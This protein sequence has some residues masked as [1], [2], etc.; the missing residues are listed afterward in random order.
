MSFQIDK[1]FV[2]VISAAFLAQFNEVCAD[3]AAI[4][5]REAVEFFERRVWPVL[6]EH[7]V[8]CHGPRKQ[9]SGLR[10]DSREA[11]LKGGDSGPAARSAKPKES[12]LVKAVRRT[13]DLK[14]PPDKPLKP[15]QVEA[16]SRWVMLGLPWP[17]STTSPIAGGDD[18]TSHWAFQPVVRPEPPGVKD[19]AWPITDV[20]RFVLSRLEA[21]QLQ[22]APRADPVMLIRRATFDLIGL[23]PTAEEVLAFEEAFQK[24]AN[25]AWRG[26]IDRLLESPHY[27]E[28]QGRFWLDVARYADNKGYVFF[29]QK[30]FPWAWT[31]R[32]W[33]VRA[34]NED[35]PYD[36]FV[37]LQLAA[38]QMA[39]QAGS[40][41]PADL[42]AMGFLT[43]GP[44]FSNNTHDILDDRIDVVTRG[45]LGLT[46]TCARCHDHKF[47]PIPQADY[48]S[49]Y[50]VFRSSREPTL[51]PLLTAAPDTDQYRE[52]S[53]GMQERI[54]KLESFITTQRD[55]MMLGARKRAA[56]YLIAAHKKRNH[57][58]TENFMLLTDKGA[59]IPAMLRRWEAYLKRARRRK[60]PVWEAWFRFSD[61]PD[62]EFAER[63]KKVHAELRQ[64]ASASVPSPLG[65][66]GG[67][68]PDEGAVQQIESEP[69]QDST[70][71]SPALRPPSPP[72]GEGTVNALVRKAFSGEP[73][74]SMEDV[75]KIYGALLAK[76]DLKWQ[77]Q[78]ERSDAA[79]I[80]LEDDSAE[81][82][83]QVLYGQGSPPMV[84]QELGWGFLDLLPDRPTQGEFKK[85][86]GEVE[87]FS[88]SGAGAPPRAMVLVD[89]VPYE[90]VIFQRGNPNREGAAVPRR[91]LKLLSPADRPSFATGSGRL[92]L[93]RAIVDPKNPLTA[94]VLVNRIWQQHFGTGLVET[95][96]DF[97][98]RSASPSHPKLLDWLASEFV[99]G[100]WSIKKLH[101]L[102]MTSA[103]Y[104]QSSVAA[105][106]VPQKAELADSAN[107][108]LWKFPRRRLG[109]EAM[110]DAHLAVSGALDRRL[111]GAPANVLS[112]YNGRRTL[113]GFVNRMDLPGLMRTFDFPEPAATSP[114][115]ES[116][117]VPQQALFFLNHSFVS[118]TAARVLRR[119]DVSRF[120][121]PTE[122]LG[123]IHRILFGRSPS[124][125]ELALAGQFLNQPDE[126]TAPPTAWEY[127]YGGVDEETKRVSKFAELA[128]WTGSRWQAGPTLPDGKLGWVFHDKTGGHPA[129]SNDRC[130]VLRWTAPVTG[131][132][133]ISGKLTHRPEPGNG[134]RGRIVSSGHGILG[135]WK[136]DQSEVD[137][138][139]AKV[140]AKAGETIDFV[141][142][143]QGHI[144]HDEFE[145]PIVISQLTPNRRKSQW[146]SKRDFAGAGSDPW[147]DYVHALMMTNEFVFLE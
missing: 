15:D 144:T 124:D 22:P 83:R 107:R 81:A 32:D 59:I 96:S 43:L 26:L 70:T 31:Y 60:D 20:D 99:A 57:P 27:G 10:L 119:A 103:A 34:F 23:P 84:P 131:E 54:G 65:G 30:N 116:T 123:Q 98:L 11:I 69:K 38:D 111:G 14:M 86:L 120:T 48:Y 74:K 133:E 105:P 33:V 18:R 16:I 6:V 4:T 146:D 62:A 7:C 73:P 100:S 40:G 122:K 140:S 71:P 129:S 19:K 88:T 44:R 21:K 141:V 77:K 50:G 135:E 13:G 101:R 126:E 92:E 61:L 114:G 115:R 79:A 45:L 125:D 118:E 113:Y 145:W 104:R 142:D 63:A 3:E 56:E 49:L 42:A 128:H 87:K 9:E 85:L 97:G 112:G 82:L 139:V 25:A 1:A 2:L 35:M 78:L 93:A 67:R 95:P 24:D 52:F 110:R 130:F 109:F 17:K 147:T 90:P 94:R 51:R 72:K 143:W 89:S 91:F 66:E 28:R 5:N 41:D 132:F 64:L 117:T 127:G 75:A 46:V 106:V 29:E 102:I 39:G 47:D 121:D 137:T 138:P 8:K 134:V 36:R 55:G 136:V 53:K 80:R 68:R 37:K 12:L 58:T 76:I 108:L